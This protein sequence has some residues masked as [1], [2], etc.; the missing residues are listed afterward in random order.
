[1]LRFMDIP[2]IRETLDYLGFQRMKL[3]SS[4]RD[5]SPDQAIDM[6][7]ENMIQ[8]RRVTGKMLTLSD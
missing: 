3:S 4:G 6:Y 1:M 2:L 5:I 7:E 8:N